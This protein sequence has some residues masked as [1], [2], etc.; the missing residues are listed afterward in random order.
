MLRDL[1]FNDETV[2][3]DVMGRV[4]PGGNFLT[5]EH[6]ASHFKKSFWFPGCINRESYDSWQKD[7]SKDLRRLL[8][9]RAKKIF[10]GLET[11]EPPEKI[12]QRIMKI[13]ADHQPD[14]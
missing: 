10:G 12:K 7:G 11:K 13:A 6:T 8:N 5:E 14:V 9:E 2:P 4:G 3:I 1:H